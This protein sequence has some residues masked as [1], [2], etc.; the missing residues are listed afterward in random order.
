MEPRRK[1]AAEINHEERDLLICD[2]NDQL[3]SCLNLIHIF[4]Q[5]IRQTGLS[6]MLK[7]RDDSAKLRKDTQHIDIADGAEAGCCADISARF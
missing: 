1:S 6:T 7:R 5:V 2:P 4:N 3:D